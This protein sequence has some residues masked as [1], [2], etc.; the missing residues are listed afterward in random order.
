MPRF[1][2]KTSHINISSAEF[3]KR[4]GR[5]IFGILKS[6]KIVLALLLE[7]MFFSFSYTTVLSHPKAQEV[8]VTLFEQS[9]MKLCVSDILT[10]SI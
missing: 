8:P 4:S 6:R 9:Q 7:K 1:F 3:Y 5:S 10:E 2:P